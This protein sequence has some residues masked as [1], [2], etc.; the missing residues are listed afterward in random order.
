MFQ[1][2]ICLVMDQNPE[3]IVPEG[4]V[5]EGVVP[6]GGADPMDEDAE[7]ASLLS[8][9]N[10]YDE[11]NSPLPHTPPSPDGHSP[12][13]EVGH[14][15]IFGDDEIPPPPV[16]VAP[17]APQFE[18][19]IEVPP[20]RHYIIMWEFIDQQEDVPIDLDNHVH[21]GEL[22][23]RL[24]PA[25][26]INCAGHFYGEEHDYTVFIRQLIQDNNLQPFIPDGQ[27]PPPL[28]AILN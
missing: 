4:G 5:P 25:G 17:P 11:Q 9:L 8:D 18:N 6:E 21:N 16:L 14:H 19:Q 15:N 13:A 26:G 22:S 27:A 12:V 24:L 23:V 3:E 7:T 10:D 28:E 20:P 2:F 1:A